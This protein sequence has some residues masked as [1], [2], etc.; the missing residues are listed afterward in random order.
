MNFCFLQIQ[1]YT[2]MYITQTLTIWSFIYKLSLA[3]P[4]DFARLYTEM[5]WKMTCVR[6]LCILQLS[7]VCMH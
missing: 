2:Y 7:S 1:V 4:L 3:S 5:D 6:P